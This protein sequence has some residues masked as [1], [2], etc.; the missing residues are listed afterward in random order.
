[1]INSISDKVMCDTNFAVCE[2]EES[3]YFS[4][5]T[6]HQLFIIP[7]RPTVEVISNDSGNSDYDKVEM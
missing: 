7:A 6:D 5:R 4:N 1:M 3:I 2:T